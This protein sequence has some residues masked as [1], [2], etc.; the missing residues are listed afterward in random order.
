MHRRQSYFSTYMCLFNCQR[1]NKKII[2]ANVYRNTINDGESQTSPLPIFSEGGGTSVHRLLKEIGDF[3]SRLLFKPDYILFI[4]TRNQLSWVV[5]E[6]TE[7]GATVMEQGVNLLAYFPLSSP[8]FSHYRN[9]RTSSRTHQFRGKACSKNKSL[10]EWVD[11]RVQHI[12]RLQVI[13][14]WRLPS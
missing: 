5:R 6:G 10:R 1:K 7:A 14:S 8:F 2:Y 11:S 3:R 4:L 12:W 13:G 9:M